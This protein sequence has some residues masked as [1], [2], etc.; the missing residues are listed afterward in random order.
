MRDVA[1]L[2]DR[3]LALRVPDAYIDIGRMLG[4][5]T[6]IAIDTHER[7]DTPAGVERILRGLL[8]H[9]YQTAMRRSP[10]VGRLRRMHDELDRGE[11]TF[12]RKLRYLLW[13]N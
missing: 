1:Q 10:L 9:G 2:V 7:D 11:D 3:G 4:D 13:L 6:D 12:E 8:G 5:P